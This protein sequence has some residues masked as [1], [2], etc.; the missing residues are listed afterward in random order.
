MNTVHILSLLGT[1]VLADWKFLHI[2]CYRISTLL[3]SKK[4]SKFKSYIFHG[5]LN[6]LSSG[7]VTQ[8][9]RNVQWYKLWCSIPKTIHH[10]VLDASLKSLYDEY[11]FSEKLNQIEKLEDEEKLQQ[12]SKANID[13]LNKLRGSGTISKLQPAW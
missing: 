7:W 12:K 11:N 6:K 2:D 1:S 5:F 10:F 3:D 8:L 9:E 4:S 13:I